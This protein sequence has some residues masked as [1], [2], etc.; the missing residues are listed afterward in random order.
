MPPQRKTISDDQLLRRHGFRI[1]ARP[2]GR[3][4]LWRRGSTV[5]PLTQAVLVAWAEEQAEREA[6]SLQ[7]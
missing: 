6:E 4:P 3:S 5:L 2:K 7:F 1:E